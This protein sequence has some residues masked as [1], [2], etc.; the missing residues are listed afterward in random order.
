MSGDEVEEGEC[1]HLRG[2]LL[3]SCSNTFLW[4]FVES[5]SNNGRSVTRERKKRI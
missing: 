3:G 1:S 2:R 5:S 4:C